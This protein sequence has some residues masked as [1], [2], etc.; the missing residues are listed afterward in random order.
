MCIVHTSV[1]A[2][3]NKNKKR[4]KQVIAFLQFFWSNRVT[5]IQLD[6]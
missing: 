3:Y 5:F 6:I 2:A 4:H 1:Y